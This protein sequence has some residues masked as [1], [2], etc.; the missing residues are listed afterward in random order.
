MAAEACAR[1]AGRTHPQPRSIAM[2]SPGLTRDGGQR[3]RTKACNEEKGDNNIE[4]APTTGMSAHQG[5]HHDVSVKT[6]YEFMEQ[7]T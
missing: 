7:H 4:C 5:Y 3:K 2:D 1:L 6:G